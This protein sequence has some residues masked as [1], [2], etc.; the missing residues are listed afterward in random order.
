MSLRR[1]SDQETVRRPPRGRQHHGERQPL[2]Q[3][4]EPKRRVTSSSSK[5]R[6]THQQAGAARDGCRRAAR[7]P[8]SK[9]DAVPSTAQLSRGVPNAGS[10]PRA[11]SHASRPTTTRPNTRV[12]VAAA[13]AGPSRPMLALGGGHG[14]SSRRT[15][16]KPGLVLGMQQNA[17]GALREKLE[18]DLAH[19]DSVPA[20]VHRKP[21]Q[22]PP[23]KAANGGARFEEW[24]RSA[25][26][27][28]WFQQQMALT[29][30]MAAVYS[31]SS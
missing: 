8:S 26:H 3:H 10:Y 16:P 20:V 18:L 15:A 17:V 5:R 4:P 6:A 14:V 9:V 27:D 29:N 13:E 11:G 2:R 22:E 19:I 28:K 30:A 7:R 12:H 23:P 25:A 1:P 31:N 21:A 24:R